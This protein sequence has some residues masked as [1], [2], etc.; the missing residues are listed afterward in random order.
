[1]AAYC[2]GESKG[3]FDWNPA[4][5]PEEMTRQLKNPGTGDKDDVARKALESFAVGENS[6]YAHLAR[7]LLAAGPDRSDG[8]IPDER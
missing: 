3:P 4:S 6:L 5:R 1:M 7:K 8:P 2:L